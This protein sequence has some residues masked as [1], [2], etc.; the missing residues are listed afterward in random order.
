M[1]S[2]SI[3]TN[4][5]FV[6]IK[7]L[8]IEYYFMPDII[9]FYKERKYKYVEYNKLTLDYQN[10][11]V[12]E[13]RYFPKDCKILEWVWLYSRKNG[14]P[15]CR[16]KNNYQIPVVLYGYFRLFVMNKFDREFYISNIYYA[17]Q[18]YESFINYIKYFI[19]NDSNNKSQYYSTGKSK[20][21]FKEVVPL[22]RDIIEIFGIKANASLNEITDAYRKLAKLHHPDKFMTFNHE[23]RRIEEE[24]MKDINNK[25]ELAISMR[26]RESISIKL[27]ENKMLR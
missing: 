1:F 20:D 23:T 16:Y 15:D 27:I 14:L 18:L 22:T 9:I 26:K 5:K 13:S 7:E 3:N 21:S 19:I 4:L 11:K 24:K 8:N 25:Y 10:I 6:G 17:K 12:Y 2:P